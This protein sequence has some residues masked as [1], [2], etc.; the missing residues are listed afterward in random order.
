MNFNELKEK[1]SNLPKYPG[2]TQV[3]S[4]PMINEGY[5]SNF[6]LSFA[7]YEWTQKEGQKGSAKQYISFAGDMF[8]SKCQPCIR[9]QDWKTIV[10]N[11]KDKYR[12]LSYFHMMD[13][14]GLIA[15]TDPE[16][17]IEIGNFAINSLI[18][19]F[20]ELD[21]D[22]NKVHIA[23]C[24]GGKV[25]DLS[26]GKYTFDKNVP[27]DPFYDEWIRV[28]IPE[29]NMVCDK[30]RDT[31]LSLRNYSRPSPW[32]YRNEIFYKHK[33]KL[34]DIATIEHL[35]FEPVFDEQ[36]NIIDIIDYRHSF[37]ISAVG[38]ERLL[39]VLNHLDDIRQV[40]ILEPLFDYIRNSIDG[41]TDRDADILIQTIRP[42]QAI[43]SD[44]GQWKNLNSRRKELMRAFYMEFANICSKYNINVGNNIIV[45][46]LKMNADLLSNNK[47]NDDIPKILEE[48]RER[49]TFLS[50]NKHLPEKLRA[51][52]KLILGDVEKS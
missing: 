23:Y 15:R 38:M 32:G 45:D 21:L 48:I 44:G 49:I 8:Y 11:G 25:S 30:T 1:L 42:I 7:Y 36:M 3:N 33:G 5:P 43:I 14:S 41:V 19:L 34:L 4:A 40:D 24:G 18:T 50:N 10:E 16:Y 51:S 35:C 46:L 9:T 20:K 12:Y 29:K 17:Q 6:N 39:V 26:N 28:G 2:T 22:L 52:C 31:F 27:R 37:S 47:Y 13:V